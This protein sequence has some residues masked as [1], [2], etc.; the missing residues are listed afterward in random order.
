MIKENIKVY[1]KQHSI[2]KKMLSLGF[3]TLLTTIYSTSGFAASTNINDA[4]DQMLQSNEDRQTITIDHAKDSIHTNQPSSTIASIYQRASTLSSNH[5][6]EHKPKIALVLGSGGARGYAHIGVLKVL[7]AK[8]IHPDFIVGTS[9]GSIVG[10]LYASGKTASQLQ[11]IALNLKTSDV[12][13]FTLNLQGF[14]DGQKIENYINKIVADKP[15]EQMNIPLYIVATELQTGKETVF[16]EGNTGKAVRASTSIPSMFVPTEIGGREY[17]DGGLVSPLPVQIARSL[18]ADFV[19]AVDILAK[20]ENTDTRHMWGLF[21][22]NINVMQ[23]RLAAYEAQQADVLIQ[24][25]IRDKQHV[26]STKSR[27]ESIAAGQIS[28]LQ[29]LPNIQNLLALYKNHPMKSLSDQKSVTKVMQKDIQ[30]ISSN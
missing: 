4:K 20:P 14:F 8:G 9:A 2:L 17:V 12:R 21:N 28:A 3:V 10:A 26:F 19:I 1:P 24:P 16:H 7:E 29:Q 5:Q 30:Y 11:D 22:Q 6:T 18:G 27:A 15:I 25:D 23:N 13:D